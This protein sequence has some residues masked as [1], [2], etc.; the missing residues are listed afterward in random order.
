[1][2]KFFVEPK[3]IGEQ[4]I[5]IT[6]KEDIHHLSKVLRLKIG[7]DIDI[8]DSLTWDYK[9]E[10][11]SINEK[12]VTLKILDKQKFSREPGIKV[13]LFQGIPKA[14]KM[15]II[16]Q[17]CVEMGVYSIVPVLMDR[18]IVVD[19]GN[20]EKKISRWQKISDESVKQCKRG[21]IPEIK[22]TQNFD[23]SIKDLS[24]FDLVIF[25]YENESKYTIKN[26][27]RSLTQKPK[28]VAIIIGP[29]G[30]FSEKEVLSLDAIN[31]QT[32]T[33]GKTILRTD[34]P[35]VITLAMIMY[36]LEL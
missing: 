36:E 6:S 32:V 17:K 20:F 8:S 35:G 27:L 25:P 33:L 11:T 15:D 9:A 28:N 5:K 22:T 31:A 34:T 18:T 24:S 19:K 21:I 16:V 30:G 7:D 1:M 4:Y 3:N 10:I 29:E 14:G 2:S 12:E 13:T 23:K 26:C